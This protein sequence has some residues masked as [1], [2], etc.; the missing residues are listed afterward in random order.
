MQRWHRRHGPSRRHRSCTPTI[1][2]RASGTTKWTLRLHTH[3][4]KGSYVA[5]SRATDTAGNV[6][7]IGPS[8]RASFKLV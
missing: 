3:L 2:L 7:R 5:I 1:F 8:D 6:E 4:P